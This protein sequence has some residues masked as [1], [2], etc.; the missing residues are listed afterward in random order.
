MRRFLDGS[1]AI[2][3]RFANLDFRPRT[4]EAFVMDFG[5]GSEIA[6]PLT[7]DPALLARAI[8]NAPQG[9]LNALG[10]TALYSAIFRTC[11]YEFGETDSA[12][13][14]NVILLLSDGEDTAGKT[15]LEEAVKACQRSNTVIYAFR[16]RSGRHL[17]TGPKA[18]A[19][20]TEK[21]GGRVFVYD[22]TEGEIDIDL[23][24]IESEVRN[25]YRL[26]YA[27]A[28]FKHDG[29]FHR[30]ELQLPD[31]VS[32]FQVRTGYYSPAQ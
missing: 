25:Q 3:G 9:D 5:Y 16:P 31:R 22:S 29:S 11:F 27:P 18:L 13:T 14:G 7:G 1:K 4:D 30:I 2:A 20:L 21:T 19:E 28:G 24:T 10:G 6:Q 26:V 23:K 32:R 17:S 12:P 15:S 8:S